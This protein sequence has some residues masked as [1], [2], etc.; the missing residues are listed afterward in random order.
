M[1]RG[2]FG[3]DPRWV[4][5]RNSLPYGDDEDND[6]D[7]DD[8]DDS[9]NGDGHEDDEDDDGDDDDNDD[10]DSAHDAALWL[11]CFLGERVTRAADSSSTKH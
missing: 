7:G 11:I 10:N 6:N 9:D 2:R 5:H 3:S 8:D 1:D 4:H